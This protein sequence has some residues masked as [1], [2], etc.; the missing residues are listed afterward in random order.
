VVD[1]DNDDRVDFVYAGD[2]TGNMWK[3]D[4]RDPEPENW[5]VIYGTDAGNPAKVDKNNQ[6][7]ARIDY[8]D[9]NG[10]GERDDPK[11]LINVGRPITTAPDVA[12]HCEEHGY[13]VVF[14]TG[15]FLGGNDV[16]DR[17][18]QGIFGIWDFGDNPKDY[19]GNWKSSDNSFPDP[20]R[21]ELKK[22]QLLDQVEI[23]W[24]KYYGSYLR[25]LSD[26]KPQWSA[27]DLCYNDIDDD[28]DLIKDNESC[29]PSSG[30]VGWYFDLPYHLGLDGLDNDSDG[31]V[32]ED[33]E[34]AVLAG[35]RVVKD[36]LIRY[37]NAVVISLIPGDSPCDGGGNSI[38]HEMPFCTGGR[39]TESVFDINNDGVID[40][41]DVLLD[42][43][44]KP[45]LI[46]DENGNPI[47]LTDENGDTIVDENGNPI[48]LPISPNGRM[49]DGILH[50]PVVIGDP[51]EEKKR[52][53]KIF[54]SSAGTT[55]VMW[56][57]KEKIGF[58][59]WKEH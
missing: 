8:N 29:V 35:E 49:Y 9:V 28:G 47:Y 11:P 31:E 4:L 45:I 20:G 3:F 15:K 51:D 1:I 27:S 16:S 2:L 10:N 13:I 42:E 38:V 40:E 30:H 19:L 57:K 33:D 44:G 46:R 22:V 34:S 23:D 48:P 59:Y 17:S 54:S 5:G 50:K 58:Y 32:D 39:L 56:E 53:L 25:T 12:Y 41:D 36:V 7:V 21:A 55:E 43:N 52:E 18:Q 6:S 24:R 37:G 14:G 26:K